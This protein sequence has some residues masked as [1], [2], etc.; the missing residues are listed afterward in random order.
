MIQKKRHGRTGA[1]VWSCSRDESL[2]AGWGAGREGDERG[3]QD[4][5]NIPYRAMQGGGRLMETGEALAP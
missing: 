1:S 5:G 3:L 2:A 4:S